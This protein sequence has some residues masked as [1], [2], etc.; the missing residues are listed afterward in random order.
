MVF[1]CDDLWSGV[2]CYTAQPHSWE[3]K[4]ISLPTTI[5]VYHLND[6]IN[7]YI[8]IS[9]KHMPKLHAYAAYAYVY[10]MGYLLSIL[11][12][13]NIRKTQWTKPSSIMPEGSVKANTMS[14]AFWPCQPQTPCGL[15]QSTVDRVFTHT[16]RH[17]Q[18]PSITHI[19]ISM[20]IHVHVFLSPVF[21]PYPC[22]LLNPPWLLSGK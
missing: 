13:L 2:P 6:F 11:Q 22:F 1:F 3:T 17:V 8:E 7:E 16:Y 10:W 4:W 21:V 5:I 20:I 18:S 14:S 12:H 19:I 15:R 9:F